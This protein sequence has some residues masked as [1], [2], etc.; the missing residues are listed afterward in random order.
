V[1]IKK[2]IRESILKILKESNGEKILTV[3]QEN[4]SQYFIILEGG[5]K[6]TVSSDELVS[7]LEFYKSK[8]YGFVHDDLTDDQIDIEMFIVMIKPL[9]DEFSKIGGIS[10]E[11][12][13]L[14]SQFDPD[15]QIYGDNFG[16]N[17]EPPIYSDLDIFDEPL[18]DVEDESSE[19]YSEFDDDYI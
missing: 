5:E 17:Y 14:L 18:I 16:R 1:K 7:K 10:P 4:S 19:E 2:L 11:E 3:G 13:M 9:V 8:N 6:I 12:E 15:E